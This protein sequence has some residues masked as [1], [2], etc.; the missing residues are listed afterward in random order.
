MYATF[1][2]KPHLP[3]LLKHS[4]LASTLLFS[5]HVSAAISLLITDQNN[6]ALEHAIIE[7][8][9]L[10]AV[11]TNIPDTPLV[12]DQI[13]KAFSP[14]VLAV[15]ATSYVSFPNSDDIRHHVYSFSKAKPFE[16]KLYA[17]Q[18][19]S[20]IFFENTGVVVLG[21]NIH[22]A[23]VGYI[24]V[25]NNSHVYMSNAKGETT[26]DIAPSNIKNAWLWHPR[27]NNGVNHKQVINL[28]ELKQAKATVTLTL[29]VAP[30][31]A[32]GSFQD[33]F[34]TAN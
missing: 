8:E 26:I 33:V 16:L 23:M 25:Y 30:V 6:Q 24:Y 21:C 1:D 27:N 4:F 31:K 7:I 34:K 18:P 19:K 12:M 17:G 28:A 11:Q 5:F 32:T 3:A 2:E 15:P 29:S 9:T 14:H 22:D 10:D 20:P 13:D